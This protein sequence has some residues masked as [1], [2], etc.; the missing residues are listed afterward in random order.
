[1]V[2]FTATKEQSFVCGS[3]ISDSSSSSTFII[4]PQ[5]LIDLQSSADLITV[6]YDVSDV[7]NR[8]NI[9]N[10][11]N[12]LIVTSGWRGTAAYPGPWGASISTSPTGTLSFNKSTSGGDQRWY[13]LTAEHAGNANTSDSW[14]AQLTCSAAPSPT[15]AVVPSV[16]SVNEGG[17]VTFTVTT[18]NIANGTTLY[19]TTAGTVTAGD[20]TD[21]T[22]FGTV[23]INN[24]T[25]TITRSITSDAITEGAENFTLSIRTGSAVGT[26]V[27]TATQVT[28]NDTSTTPVASPT[29]AIVPN[30]TS[31]N[32]GGSVT[33]TVT[34]TNVTNGTILYWT[35]NAGS[36]LV[37]GDF[38]GGA[39]TG[40]VTI[41]NNTGSIVRSIVND[42]TTE[43]AETFSLA[44]RTVSTS[45]TT[46]ATS[47]TVTINDTSINPSTGLNIGLE[48]NLANPGM[49]DCLGT[50]YPTENQFVTATLY[51]SSGV[52]VNAP[53][54]IVVTFNRLFSPCY[55]GGDV[56]QTGS[57]TILAGQSTAD[58]QTWQSS[59][60]VDCGQFGCQVESLQYDCALSNSAGYPW[61]FGTFSCDDNNL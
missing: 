30:V 23:V 42:T 25:G 2:T 47:A 27:A 36:G 55:G 16:T 4:Y 14:T 37:A 38:T 56:T 48:L 60:T 7:P 1:V 24:N 15:Y 26:I 40:Q 10:S 58:S 13:Y 18:T 57:V 43:G 46:V 21:N 9:Y 20:F 45:G 6:N 50:A 51:N 22:T 34:T 31:V 49:V 8:L 52:P 5:K 35:T 11:D 17:T 33:F 3:T 44:L 54:D 19:Y 61:A 29:Y 39:L 59:T 32:E 28:I 53:T 12:A 41:N